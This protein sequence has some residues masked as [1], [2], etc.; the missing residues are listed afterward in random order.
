MVEP[1]RSLLA[2]ILARNNGLPWAHLLPL[3]CAGQTWYKSDTGDDVDAIGYGEYEVLYCDAMA[4]RW[5][6][7]EACGCVLRVSDLAPWAGWYCIKEAPAIP[8]TRSTATGAVALTA[9]TSP[10]LADP[11]LLRL[12]CG[13]RTALRIPVAPTCPQATLCLVTPVVVHPAT[14]RARLAGMARRVAHWM[15]GACGR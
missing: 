7:R 2:A 11:A 14:Y 9:V 15:H 3:P 1:V 12:A 13:Y 4:G 8:P 6:L 10:V 5:V